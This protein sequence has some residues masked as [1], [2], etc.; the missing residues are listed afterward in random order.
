MP[1]PIKVRATEVRFMLAGVV[2]A[3]VVTR[4]NGRVDVAEADV[5]GLG[6]GGGGGVPG[7]ER[8]AT[9]RR[10]PSSSGP[11]PALL[12]NQLV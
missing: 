9:S 5:A 7:S 1:M 8:P 12:R 2:V 11:Q 3:L 6:G 10:W 4:M